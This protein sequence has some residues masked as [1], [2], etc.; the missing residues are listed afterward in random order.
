M[1]A[2]WCIV[3][4]TIFAGSLFAQDLQNENGETGTL[5]FLISGPHNDKGKNAFGI[6]KEQYWFLNNVRATFGPPAYEKAQFN[7]D[8][9]DMVIMDNRGM[10]N[11][12]TDC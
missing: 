8:K 1:A 12:Q 5:V 6:T 9:T 3:L 4:L 10:K 11:F 2:I 7:C